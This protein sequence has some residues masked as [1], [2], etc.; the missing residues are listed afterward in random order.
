MQ[1]KRGRNVRQSVARSAP[2]HSPADLSLAVGDEL[3]AAVVVVEEL[4]TLARS[5]SLR[6]L[7]ASEIPADLRSIEALLAHI[8]ARIDVLDRGGALHAA[9]HR[10]ID[11]LL[12]A[13]DRL[14]KAE[15]PGAG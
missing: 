4:V 10:R 8:T 6:L 7:L 9:A 15:D 14:K 2:T 12:T 5:D 3:G 13:R 1:P 11:E